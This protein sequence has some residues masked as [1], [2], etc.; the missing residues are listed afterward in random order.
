MKPSFLAPAGLR[1]A[2]CAAVVGL[3]SLAGTTAWA[4]EVP[5]AAPVSPLAA[6]TPDAAPPAASKIDPEARAL[7][8]QMAKA[9][10]ALTSFSGTMDFSM[11]QGGK[12]T[13]QQ[14]KIAYE[15][16]NKARIITNNPTNGAAVFTVSNGTSLFQ[17]ISTDKNGYHKGTAAPNAK[18]IEQVFGASKAAGIGL[19]PMLATNPKAGDEVLPPGVTALVH[20]PDETINGTLCDVLT[21]SFGPTPDTQVS[22]VFGIG[23]TDH[24]LRR[25]SLTQP[26][27]E[28]LGLNETYS[29]VQANPAL[30][31]STFAFT[32]ALGMKEIKPAA[33]P[34]DAEPAAFDARLK[35]G[36]APL[37]FKG[38]DLAG[39]PVSLAAYKGKVVLLDFWATWCP[40]CREEIPN[41]VR[42]YNKYHAGGL[43]IVGVSL[44]REGDKAKL[45]SYTKE[46]KMP[47]RQV[48]D[49][50]FWQAAMA[51]AYSV[52][53]I[54]FSVL[55]GRDGKILAVGNAL[56]GEDLEPAIKA[57]LARK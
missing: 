41:L 22:L 11:K 2:F 57:A 28:K 56:R 24:L 34:P 29:D 48:Y 35:K 39:K 55:V 5:P 44:D 8:E 54:P 21:A 38:N 52:Q 16:P 23:K 42:T 14:A 18:A 49:G 50:K 27:G 36:A 37:P 43:E 30:P 46:N 32:P 10:Q 12:T 31:P 45:V 1:P 7:L 53:S 47:W 17:T 13:K 19:F 6:K 20:G 25:L 40:P 3:A 26:T 33:P 4:Q 51:Q 15:K 9:H